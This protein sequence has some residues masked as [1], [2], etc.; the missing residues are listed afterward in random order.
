MAQNIIKPVWSINKILNG[1]DVVKVREGEKKL[2]FSVD[3][4]KP[5]FP[6]SLP[7]VKEYDPENIV[8][9]CRTCGLTFENIEQRNEHYNTDWHRWNL[10]L[11]SY[12]M[13]AIPLEEFESLMQAGDMN[14]DYLMNDDSAE[15]TVILKGS[16]KI[17]FYTTN[18]KKISVWKN[19][20]A[21]PADLK[22][23]RARQYVESLQNLANFNKIA[24]FMSMGGRFAAGIFQRERCLKHKTFVRY[25]V[26]KKQG[27]SQSARDGKGASGSQPKSMGAHMRRHHTAKFIEDVETV[28][29]DWREDLDACDLIFL[30]APS[31]NMSYFRFPT[32]PVQKDDP[33]VRNVPFTAARP[34]LFEVKRILHLLI[35]VELE[36]Y[37]PSTSFETE[38]AES[39]AEEEF[40]LIEDEIVTEEPE[41]EDLL[42]TAIEQDNF[43]EFVSLIESGYQQPPDSEYGPLYLACKLNRLSIIEYILIEVDDEFIDERIEEIHFGTSLH[44]A[45]QHGNIAI[46]LF[47]LECGADPTIK[48]ISNKTPIQLSK[49]KNTRLEFRKFAGNNLDMWD[50]NKA[51]VV[52]LT[53]EMIENQK[54]KAAER[55]RRKR[56][57]KK[58]RKLEQNKSQQEEEEDKHKQESIEMV[59]NA[60]KTAIRNISEREKRALAIER[61][62]AI[63]RNSAPTCDYCHNT[64]E[65]IPFER[66]EYKYCSTKCVRSHMD[67]LE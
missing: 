3:D 48:N 22:S 30:F 44:F 67:K 41:L 25:T 45:C 60:R 37:Y 8:L 5:T 9:T 61:K 14:E 1:A 51:N 34:T 10:K 12:G 54:A 33:R 2:N 21:S 52:P 32:S 66:L 63:Q 53:E 35:H 4:I 38:S 39:V 13:K 40:V 50:W 7:D 27:G 56:K 57:N 46:L 47:L 6:Q 65:A 28:L 64:L 62:M 11:K 42:Y 15:E 29:D 59:S 18:H 58:N 26:R 36:P 16:S 19:M 24:I 23:F 49:T 43:D 31:Q 17:D 20:L 55:R